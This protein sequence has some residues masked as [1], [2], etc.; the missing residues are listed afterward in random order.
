MEAQA[1]SVGAAP[2]MPH[3]RRSLRGLV[4][5]FLRLGSWGFGGPI[6][7]VGYMR[8]D[9]VEERRWYSEPEFQQALAVGQTM[10]GPLAAQVAMWLGYLQ[11]GALGALAV[12][13]PFVFPPFVFV[14]AVAVFYAKYQGLAWVHE[15][16]LGV[17][18]AVLAIICWVILFWHYRAS[19]APL[20]VRKA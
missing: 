12:A 15:V 19:F 14:T 11:A 16:F 13:V 4:G 9:L 2:A 5:Y 18:P 1:G 6:A 3:G 17:G 8:R 10:P 20:W 7:L